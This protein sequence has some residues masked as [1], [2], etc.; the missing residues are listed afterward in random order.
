MDG[1]MDIPSQAWE[2][3]GGSS[4][5]APFASAQLVGPHELLPAWVRVQAT[6]RG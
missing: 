5:V 4:I 2:R 3:R 6:A 1:Q